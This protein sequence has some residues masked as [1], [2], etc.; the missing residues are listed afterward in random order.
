MAPHP[1]VTPEPRRPGP[2]I[3]P[4]IVGQP[5]AEARRLIEAAGLFNGYTNYQ[6]LGDVANPAHYLATAPGAVLSQQPPGGQTLDPGSTVLIAVAHP[7]DPWPAPSRASTSGATTETPAPVTPTAAPALAPLADEQLTPAEPI[8]TATPVEGGE[9]VLEAGDENVTAGEPVTDTIGL[10][11]GPSVAEIVDPG[12]AEPLPARSRPA[13]LVLPSSCSRLTIPGRLQLD[14]SAFQRANCGVASLG[15][16]LSA[17]GVEYPTASLR[18]LANRIQPPGFYLDGLAWETL[19][20][21]ASQFG[22]QSRGLYAGGHYRRWTFQDLRDELT[23]GHPIITLVHYRSLPVNWHSTSESDHYIVLT[24]YDGSDFIYN[25]PAPMAGTGIDTRLNAADLQDAWDTSSLPGSALAL[26]SPEGVI[27]LAPDVLE[28][29]PEDQGEETL[30]EDFVPHHPGQQ[31]V[32]VQAGEEGSTSRDAVDQGSQAA[33]CPLEPSATAVA[34]VEPMAAARPIES[35]PTPETNL[36][37][38]VEVPLVA[39]ANGSPEASP[40][41][42]AQ[43]TSLPISSGWL[44]IGGGALGLIVGWLPRWRATRKQ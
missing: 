16:I 29:T 20:G 3:V 21:V 15:M 19:V 5:E 43:S 40:Q 23:A 38:G 34:V 27:G 10:G 13:P 14:G 31:Y 18:A 44:L 1:E 12:V 8:P 33:S 28:T 39:P 41:L 6:R 35:N 4:D 36:V 30:A 32:D 42:V 26:A 2:V 37:G 24:G 25:D 7:A 22:L 17:T 9:R 11:P